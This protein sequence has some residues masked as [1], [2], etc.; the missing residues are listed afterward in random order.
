MGWSA[1]WVSYRLA[2]A[3][4]QGIAAQPPASR[5]GTSVKSNFQTNDGA[6]AIA[7]NSVN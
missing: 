5:S 1:A 6:N 3:V 2:G 7:L 4:A